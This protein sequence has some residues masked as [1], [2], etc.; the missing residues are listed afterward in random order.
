MKRNIPSLN[1]WGGMTTIFSFLLYVSLLFPFY[2]VAQQKSISFESIHAEQGLSQNT[3]HCILQDS[4]GFMWFGTQ[5]GLNRYDGYRFT[6]FKHDSNN[7]RSLSNNI[8]RA[9][10]EDHSATIWVGTMVGLN[11]LDR[12][13]GQSLPTMMGSGMKKAL[14]L[15][16][17]SPRPSGKRCGSGSLW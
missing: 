5:D 14:R 15:K 11:K 9:V 1:M 10:Y 12:G 6:T 2:A 8:V 13:S 3:V 17:P 7:P 4:R 16:S